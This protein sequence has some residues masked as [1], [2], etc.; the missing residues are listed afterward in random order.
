M[1][2]SE[3]REIL[4]KVIKCKST[5]DIVL[6]GIIEFAEYIY[7]HSNDYEIVTKFETEKIEIGQ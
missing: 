7:R 1:K 5:G 4:G 6:P 2:I 3:P